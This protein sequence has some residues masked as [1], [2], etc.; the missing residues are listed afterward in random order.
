[1]VPNYPPGYQPPRRELT[2]EERAEVQ[3]RF[4]EAAAELSTS[5]EHL[6]PD[7][8]HMIS[9]E[10]ESRDLAS[11]SMTSSAMNALTHADLAERERAEQE[12]AEIESWVTHLQQVGATLDVSVLGTA[13][14]DD[15]VQHLA[16]WVAAAE[17]FQSQD[18][19]GGFEFPDAPPWQ[20]ARDQ[21]AAIRLSISENK[22]GLAFRLD[23]AVNGGAS[24][25]AFPDLE[26]RLDALT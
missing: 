20:A 8:V 17:S 22:A 12:R 1:M 5:I 23:D 25:A 9:A 24:V 14:G 6:P 7:I 18:A 16:G 10:L 2:D 13:S 11:L 4:E 15:F 3:R 26:Q 21:V 19:A